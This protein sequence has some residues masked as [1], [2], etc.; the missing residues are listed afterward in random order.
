M[1]KTFDKKLL[2]FF[3]IIFQIGIF[4]AVLKFTYSDDKV[5]ILNEQPTSEQELYE[6][7][8]GLCKKNDSKH[9][10][11]CSRS[12]LC[13]SDKDTKS[14]D[15]RLDLHDAFIEETKDTQDSPQS[16][17]GDG[18]GRSK[19]CGGEYVPLCC[20]A[21]AATGDPLKC[22]GYWERLWC[23]KDLCDRV[24]SSK[25]DVCGG[26]K[27][28]CGHAW[29][30]YCKA[31]GATPGKS[32]LSLCE[33]LKR[34]GVTG[35]VCAGTN[36][37]ISPT[38]VLP[39]TPTPNAGQYTKPKCVS[40]NYVDASNSILSSEARIN[41]QQTVNITLVGADDT[42]K[43]QRMDLCWAL[44]SQTNEYYT[45]PSSWVCEQLVVS[46]GA[47]SVSVTS[48]IKGKQ[49]SYFLQK[50]PNITLSQLKDFGLILSPKIYSSTNSA[51]YCSSNP[52]YNNGSGV[53]VDLSK[54]SPAERFTN[55]TCGLGTVAG[56]PTTSC[57]LKLFYTSN[58][59]GVT[60][61]LNGDGKLDISDFTL[62]VAYYKTKNVA[63][64]FNGDKEVGIYDFDYFRR[65]YISAQ[66]L[67]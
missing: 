35:I 57:I 8:E 52:A 20:Y 62:F 53:M 51:Q 27:C 48:E 32:S 56:K 23:P 11:S 9:Y 13:G 63:I 50:L 3:L 49:I 29:G 58:S 36:P 31:D 18:D 67:G 41:D 14:Q 26:G 16:C 60:Y 22:G 34:E 33:R 2:L 37:P 40:I 54:T 6:K 15:E 65:E 5:Q 39:A 24:D 7:L 12:P 45:Q 42:Q 21:M 4:V 61:D 30:S 47:N 10:N 1:Q 38:P 19:G 46:Q 25:D 55:S 28:G 17:M 59:G 44:G 64:D 43:P 66:K